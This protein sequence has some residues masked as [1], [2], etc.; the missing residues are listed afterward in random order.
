MTL[1]APS[2][3]S[4]VLIPGAGGAAW[5]WYLLVSELQRRGHRA[6]AVELPAGD[7]AADFSDYAR[8]VVEAAVGIERPILVAQSLGGFTAPLVCQQLDVRLLVLLNAM[9]PKPGESAGQWWDATGSREARVRFAAEQ[10][11]VASG[12]DGTEFFHDVPEDV[13]QVALDAGE[14]AQSETPFGPPWP[15]SAWPDVPTR[16]LSGRDDRLFPFDFQRRV[17]RERLGLPVDELPGGHLLALSR[18]VELADRLEGYLSD[19]L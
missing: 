2:K 4:F 7:D 9:V 19:G 1:P 15:L 16:V 5:Y 17:A 10:G 3:A 12:A 11:R 13:V 14:P 6:I 8:V 18:P